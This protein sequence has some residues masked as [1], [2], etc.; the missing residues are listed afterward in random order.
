MSTVNPLWIILRCQKLFLTNIDETS[1]QAQVN[2][3]LI[4]AQ[5]TNYK[6]QKLSLQILLMWQSYS[7]RPHFH[8]PLSVKLL[9]T[10]TFESVYQHCLSFLLKWY[11]Q[12]NWALWYFY[13]LVYMRLL[14]FV[15]LEGGWSNG[16]NCIALYSTAFNTILVTFQLMLREERSAGP[17][18]C[19]SQ[20]PSPGQWPLYIYSPFPH[21]ILLL[22]TTRLF[23]SKLW[24]G[25]SIEKT[26][27]TG[28][29]WEV[30]VCNTRP[31]VA[32]LTV[33]NQRSGITA[34]C[35]THL[36]VFVFVFLLQTGRGEYAYLLF[37]SPVCVCLTTRGGE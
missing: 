16:T 20:Q 24:L 31:I 4:S 1:C 8:S 27:A 5:K 32:G 35:L 15:V 19:L 7:T 34:V 10:L 6:D 11:F 12:D 17:S 37:V 2:T 28:G 18:W 26:R 14:V 30:V 33:A 36:F 25:T 9:L 13:H 23:H 3:T 21:S 29:I 22:S